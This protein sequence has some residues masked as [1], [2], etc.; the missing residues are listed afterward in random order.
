MV[1]FDAKFHLD[2]S[3]TEGIDAH[4]L[5]G[6]TTVEEQKQFDYP[7]GIILDAWRKAHGATSYLSWQQTELLKDALSDLITEHRSN[8]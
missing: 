1:T 7:P 4:I 2:L 6:I 3:K 5:I 8:S